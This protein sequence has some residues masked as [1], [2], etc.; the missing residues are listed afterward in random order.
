MNLGN[1]NRL[2]VCEGFPSRANVYIAVITIFTNTPVTQTAT[3]YETVSK[4]SFI[5][6]RVFLLYFGIKK[7][8][9]TLH[10]KLFSYKKT[11]WR[12][13]EKIGTYA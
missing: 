13:T 12:K 6:E 11:A 9:A 1:Q 7:K 3:C 4:I 8:Y 10:H 2:G 5:L